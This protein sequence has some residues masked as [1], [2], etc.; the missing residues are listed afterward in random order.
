MATARS[1]MRGTFRLS[2]AFAVLAA[3]F[4]AFQVFLFHER[5]ETPFE[6]KDAVEFAFVCA[7]LALIAVNLFGLA[8]VAARAVVGWIRAGYTPRE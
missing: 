1:I 5:E 3:A 6:V 7:L 2:L 4:G 8:F